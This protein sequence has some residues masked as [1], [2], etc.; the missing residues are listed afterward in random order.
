MTRPARP[1]A[2]AREHRTH[3][4]R[5]H[6]ALPERR[7]SLWL[8]TAGPTVWALHFLACY[9]TAAIWCAKAG[10]AGATLGDA[11]TALWAYTAVA[12]VAITWFGARGLRGHRLGD[13]TL[14]HDDDTP[15]D[16]HRFLGFATL[17]LCGLSFVAVV[18][19]A[20]AVAVIGTCR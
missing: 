18:Y 15:G 17:L 14:P 9:V 5:G 1:H 2:D 7:A 20:L 4:G 8:L 10:S 6:A 12:L 3:D 11:R 19:V 16:R 13:A